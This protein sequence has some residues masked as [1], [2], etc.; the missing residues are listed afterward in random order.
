MKTFVMGDIHGAFKALRQCL[1]RSKF[2]Y[3]NDRLIC[4]GDYVDGWSESPEVVE[5]LLKIKHLFPLKGNH[6]VWFTEYLYGGKAEKIWLNQGGQATLDAYLKQTPLMDKH[7]KEF[8]SKLLPYWVDEH[9]NMYVHGGYE[10]SIPLS[11]H[12]V[13]E[14]TWNR[15]LYNEACLRHRT[16]F[17]FKEFNKIFIGHTTTMEKK[18]PHIVCNVVNVDQG[19]GWNGRLTILNTESM[20]YFQSDNV[21]ILYGDEYVRR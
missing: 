10:P 21:K 4:V 7:R 13:D 16:G 15:E 14:F 12:T 1:N 6:D 18:C 2:N 3:D 8:F 17:T 5:E 11:K 19:A 20:E 9:N